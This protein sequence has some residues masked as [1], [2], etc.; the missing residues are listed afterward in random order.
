MCLAVVSTATGIAAVSAPFS[1]DGL[2]LPL[3]QLQNKGAIDSSTHQRLWQRDPCKLRVR[4]QGLMVVEGTEE[5]T[6]EVQ[7]CV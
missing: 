6:V 2:L 3:L 1:Y 4:S 7:D 5:P